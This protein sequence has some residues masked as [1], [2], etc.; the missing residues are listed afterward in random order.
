MMR[1]RATP[2][3]PPHSAATIALAAAVDQALALCRDAVH[4]H[5][6]NRELCDLALD[7]TN[8]LIQTP[9]FANVPITPGPLDR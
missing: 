9:A 4:T 5:S 8:T 7:I 2:P 3:P 6:G 1:G